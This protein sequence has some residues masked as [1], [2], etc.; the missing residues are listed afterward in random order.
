MA[1]L[2]D[3]IPIASECAT[4]HAESMALTSVESHLK[5]GQVTP[6]WQSAGAP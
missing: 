2:G 3:S 6:L 5:M 4:P 1:V